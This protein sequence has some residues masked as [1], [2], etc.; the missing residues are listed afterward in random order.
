[1]STWKLDV[2]ALSAAHQAV[3]PHLQEITLQE[4]GI[5]VEDNLSK[6]RRN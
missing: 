1:M 5:T 2:T 6:S 4:E 3:E